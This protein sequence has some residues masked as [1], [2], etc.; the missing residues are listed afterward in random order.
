MDRFWVGVC[1]EEW[2]DSVLEGWGVVEIEEGLL[3]LEGNPRQ[4]LNGCVFVLV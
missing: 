2:L 4:S 1:M 3:E